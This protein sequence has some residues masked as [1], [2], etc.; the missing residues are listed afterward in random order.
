MPKAILLAAS[1]AFLLLGVSCSG[2]GEPQVPEPQ[3]SAEFATAAE[4]A[5]EA[6]LLTPD[7]LPPGWFVEPED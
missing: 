2:G 6:A 5:V 7:D 3:V 1:T 4:T